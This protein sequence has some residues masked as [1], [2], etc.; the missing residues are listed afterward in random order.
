MEY[1]IGTIQ[2]GKLNRIV[3]KTKDIA[4]TDLDGRVTLEQTFGNTKIRDTFTVIRKY[5]TADSSDGYAYDWYIVADHYRF[6]D[7]SEEVRAEAEQQITDLEIDSIEQD[8]AIT[9]NEIAILELQE[10]VDTL[11]QED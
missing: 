6:E 10:I 1:T 4:H 5:Q 7:R 2:K 9:D 3:L 8:L 11:T